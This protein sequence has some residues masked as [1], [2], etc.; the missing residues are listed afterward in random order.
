MTTRRRRVHWVSLAST[1]AS[2]LALVALAGIAIRTVTASHRASTESAG[3]DLDAL[4]DA[5]HVQALLYQKG[6]TADYLLSGDRRWLDE[7]DRQRALVN[8]WLAGLTRQA[9]SPAAARV[10]AALIV[11]YGRHEAERARAIALFRQGD[12]EGAVKTMLAYTGQAERLRQLAD[13]LIRVRRDEVQLRLRESDE[14]VREALGK[15]AIAVLF[16]IVIAGAA[17]FLFARRVTRSAPSPSMWPGWPSRSSGPRPSWP[18]SGAG[19]RRRRRWPCSARW[20]PPWPT[21]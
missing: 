5:S 21:S 19:W 14:T 11:E 12:Q 8:T 15:I 6:F 13:E 18:S 20:R 2:V 3:S 1:V 16:A 7:L 17:G 10:T 4:R 9:R